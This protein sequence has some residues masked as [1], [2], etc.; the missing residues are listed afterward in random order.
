[1]SRTACIALILPLLAACAVQERRHNAGREMCDPASECGG[2]CEPQTGLHP[3]VYNETSVKNANVIIGLT[4]ES[5]SGKRPRI[6]VTVDGNRVYA[7]AI[8]PCVNVD[9]YFRGVTVS[10]GDRHTVRVSWKEKGEKRLVE[11]QFTV[12]EL[13]SIQIIY[14]DSVTDGG[15]VKLDVLNGRPYVY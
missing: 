13:K 3:F 1:M 10:C 15:Y 4:N 12:S 6:E 9:W 11:E 14:R 5:Y 7:G 8:S 2:K